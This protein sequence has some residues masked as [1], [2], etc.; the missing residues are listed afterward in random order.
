M[1]EIEW[2]DRTG[3]SMDWLAAGPERAAG[4]RPGDGGGLRRLCGRRRRASIETGFADIGR[5]T[6]EIDTDAAIAACTKALED[7]PSSAQLKG[8]LA[9]A[10]FAARRYG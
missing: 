9:R 5:E 10:Y 6:W 7:E 3:A 1:T 2:P 4:R 8:W